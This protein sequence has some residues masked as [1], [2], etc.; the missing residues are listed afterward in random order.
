MYKNS[1]ILQVDG[2]GTENKKKIELLAKNRDGMNDI[3]RDV[4]D[5]LV[6]TT[7]Y[8]NSTDSFQDVLVDD[9]KVRKSD[10]SLIWAATYCDDEHI[11]RIASFYDSKW[12]HPFMTTL[13]KNRKCDEFENIMTMNSNK[14]FERSF[15]KY[16]NDKCVSYYL[17]EMDSIGDI[18]K[19]YGASTSKTR[20]RKVIEMKKAL[21]S[22]SKKKRTNIPYEIGMK[23]CTMVESSYICRYNDILERIK[24]SYPII[25]KLEVKSRYK[26]LDLLVLAG[27]SLDMDVISSVLDNITCEDE[28]ISS[29]LKYETIISGIAEVTSSKDLLSINTDLAHIM[30]IKVKDDSFRD[31]VARGAA[32]AN[33][34]DILAQLDL[35]DNK[36]AIFV[37]KAEAGDSLYVAEFAHEAS[38][39]ALRLAAALSAKTNSTGIIDIIYDINSDVFNSSTLRSICDI[40][41]DYD[42]AESLEWI[43]NYN[44]VT[45]PTTVNL[46]SRAIRMG[47]IS[48]LNYLIKRNYPTNLQDRLKIAESSPSTSV[49]YLADLVDKSEILN[50]RIATWIDSKILI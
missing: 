38:K 4:F 22:K 5:D 2:N 32:R 40:C 46:T 23:V 20:L 27:R 8:G 39:G 1:I 7:K 10:S 9:L 17:L 21:I 37:G 33:R 15:N 47:S 12:N 29:R 44:E 34:D 41:V 19:D 31:G 11:E 25:P 43:I 14:E 13:F 18:V 45:E 35:L 30:S 6:L 50:K 42:A 49:I 3:D 16:Y 36:S 26:Y 48:V 28:D 24:Y